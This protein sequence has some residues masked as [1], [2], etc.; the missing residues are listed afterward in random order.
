VTD[1]RHAY[2]CVI[3]NGEIPGAALVKR[4]ARA[5]DIVI[6]ADGGTRH[7]VRLGI[8]PDVILGDLDS[9]SAADRR[10]FQDAAVL[11]IP[12]QES[13]DLEKAIRYCLRRGFGSVV[14]VG[15]VGDRLDHSTGALGC[16]KRFG[17]KIRMTLVDR[18]GTLTLLSRDESIKMSPGERF[19]LI[20]LGRCSGVRIDGARYP[21]K[22]SP[23]QLGVHEGIGN[24]AAGGTV[25]VRHEGGT[26]LL[27]RMGR[28]RGTGTPR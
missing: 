1:G 15:A 12:D 16:F 14:I 3:A 9:L 10:R 17:N 7:A 20:P 13:T 21:L 11:R 27:Y 26:L 5:A 28:G 25:R 19:S 18:G 6:C 8:R 23:L 4:L 2:A 24:S 22:G